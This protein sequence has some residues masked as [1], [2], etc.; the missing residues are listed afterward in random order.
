MKTYLVPALIILFLTTPCAY[1][2]EIPFE[3]TLYNCMKASFDDGGSSFEKSL[4]EFENEFIK[5][6]NLPNNS[7]ASYLSLFKKMANDQ[8]FKPALPEKDFAKLLEQSTPN[9]EKL[10]NCEPSKE[11]DAILEA[12][13]LRMFFISL[14]AEEQKTVY[15]EFANTI[16]QNFNP[17][18]LEYDMYKFMILM[19]FNNINAALN[20]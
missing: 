3:Q 10:N 19:E 7:A 11:Q 13:G 12:K 4:K 2:Q 15:Q 9:Q 6:N 18:E 14:S 5:A 16:I 8:N 20:N 1:S 17:K